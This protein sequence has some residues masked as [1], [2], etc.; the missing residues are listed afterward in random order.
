MARVVVSPCT[1]EMG[2]PPCR[3][4]SLRGL[5]SAVQGDVTTQRV[6]PV[7]ARFSRCQVLPQPVEMA[8]AHVCMHVIRNTLIYCNT[9]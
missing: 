8:A 6:K 2:Q 5:K 7:G 3:E 4:G 1:D 9:L